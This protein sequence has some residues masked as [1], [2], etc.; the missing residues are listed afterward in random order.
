LTFGTN[1]SFGVQP[2]REAAHMNS[3]IGS[4]ASSTPSC[5]APVSVPT[6]FSDGFEG[7]AVPGLWS[8]KT[9]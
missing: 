3:Y 8:G 7:G 5:I 1:F 4:V 6:I 2:G 9:P